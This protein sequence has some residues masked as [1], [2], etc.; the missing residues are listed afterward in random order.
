ML[1]PVT[2]LTSQTALNVGHLAIADYNGDGQNGLF[3]FFTPFSCDYRAKLSVLLQGVQAGT[4]SAPVD[5]LLA[6]ILGVHG[7][8]VADLNN[9]GRPDIAVVGFFSVGSPSRAKSWLNLFTQSGGGA[10]GLTGAYDMPIA[11]G[12]VAAGE[13]DGY[14]LNDLVVLGG[15]NQCLVLIQSDMV[16]GTFNTPHPLL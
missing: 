2:T 10:F 4:F 16:P 12:V 9:D 13:I 15:D 5:T 8:M 14:G 11:V 6:G 3:V 7:A 1:G